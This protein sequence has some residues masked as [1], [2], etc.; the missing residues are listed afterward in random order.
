AILQ[1][2]VFELSRRLH[3]AE[4]EYHSMHLQ[5]ADFKWTFYEMQKDA[6]KAHRLQEQLNALQHKI[7]T[8]DKINE[9]LDNA[10]QREHEAGLLL[11][12]YERRLQELSNRLELHLK[13]QDTNVSLMSLSNVKE[14]LR[15]RDQVLN[16]QKRLL[17][18]MEQDRHRLRE[19]LQEAEHALQQ[20]AKDKELI[21]NHMK[22]VDATL[23]AVRI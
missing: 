10:L 1:Q 14:E 4:A 7:T 2:E 19:T 8:Q 21:I 23:N 22:A 13:S 9:E 11:Q 5:L 12:K 20:A 16:H 15:R 18:D 6:E 17:K 3:T